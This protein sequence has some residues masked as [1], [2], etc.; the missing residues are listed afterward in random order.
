MDRLRS[1]RIRSLSL[2]KGI[3]QAEEAE[4][5]IQELTQALEAA[6]RTA[7]EKTGCLLM[8]LRGTVSEA[9]AGF[10]TAGISGRK[11]VQR[12]EAGEITEEELASYQNAVETGN[13][14]QLRE[15]Q[16]AAQGGS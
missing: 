11:A 13:W 7:A 3:R 8:Q 14:K 6:Q 10:G 5:R 2:K 1:S 15:I 16:E 4:A 12:F 9:Q